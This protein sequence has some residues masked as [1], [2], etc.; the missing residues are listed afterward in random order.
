VKLRIGVIC[1]VALAALVVPVL[2]AAETMYKW[3]DEKGVTHYSSEPPPE[4]ARATKLDVK[5]V[6]P[7][8]G[9]AAEEPGSFK[10][11]ARELELQRKDREGAELDAKRKLSE[12]AERCRKARIAEDQLLNVPRLY[13][14]DDKGERQLVSDEERPAELEQVRRVIKQQC[15]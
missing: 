6:P 2:A 14:Y 13:R 1:A 15:D 5:P 10:D 3:V 11:R 4:S 12:R 7:S 9:K 8:S